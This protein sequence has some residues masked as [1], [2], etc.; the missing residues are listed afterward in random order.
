MQQAMYGCDNRMVANV[1]E[2]QFPAAHGC[3]ELF[4]LAEAGL[5]HQQAGFRLEARKL[6]REFRVGCEFGVSKVDALGDDAG[7]EERTL[8]KVNQFDRSAEREYTAFVTPACG[9]LGGSYRASEGSRF[10]FTV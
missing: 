5:N 7:G 3:D 9:A 2:D 1:F 10:V 6:L 4:V 8:H